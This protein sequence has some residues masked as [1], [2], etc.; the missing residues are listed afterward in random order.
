MVKPT[1]EDIVQEYRKKINLIKF[2][3]GKSDLTMRQALYRVRRALKEPSKLKSYNVNTSNIDGGKLDKEIGIYKMDIPLV[4]NIQRLLYYH[5]GKQ[6]VIVHQEREDNYSKWKLVSVFY[7]R[8][9]CKSPE[10][11]KGEF[12]DI[13]YTYIL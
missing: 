3:T 10:C 1:L 4:K 13:I 12:Y 5:T 7:D 6:A 2:E 11:I 8:E 9:N